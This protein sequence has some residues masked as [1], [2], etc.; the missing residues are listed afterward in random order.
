MQ[1][2]WERRKIYLQNGGLDPEI[3]DLIKNLKIKGKENV[4]MVKHSD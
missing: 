2:A 1:H 4:K 3:I